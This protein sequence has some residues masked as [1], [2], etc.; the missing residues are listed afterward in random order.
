MKA[1]MLLVVGM[2]CAVSAHAGD[3]IDTI[4]QAYST[5]DKSEYQILIDYRK[6]IRSI[7]KRDI[8]LEEIKKFQKSGEY[9]FLVSTFTLQGASSPDYKATISSIGCE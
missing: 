8:T 5:M 1:M 3:D 7:C 9:A 6:H 4:F 2:L